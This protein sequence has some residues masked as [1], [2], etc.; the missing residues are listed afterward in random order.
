V[1][2]NIDWGSVP[3]WIGAI[4]TVLA[5]LGALFVFW[6][7]RRHERRQIRRTQITKIHAMPQSAYN[8]SRS[9]D[10]P[11]TVSFSA[12]VSFLLT[13]T[14]DVPAYE[15]HVNLL[16]WNWRH[17]RTVLCNRQIAVAPPS[18]TSGP[19]EMNARQLGEPLDPSPIRRRCRPYSSSCAMVPGSPGGGVT[20]TARCIGAHASRAIRRAS[21]GAES[22]HDHRSGARRCS[23]P[24]RAA[25]PVC[26]A[27][28]RTTRQNDDHEL[29]ANDADRSL[30]VSRGGFGAGR[31]ARVE[32]LAGGEGWVVGSVV[33]SGL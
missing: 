2:S 13:N 8:W 7:N 12:T 9:K 26:G 5:F 3:A 28:P 20:R 27:P 11:P 10:E 1:D 14:A 17:D 24:R 30:F 16:G 6:R 25:R 15:V 23:I 4:G 33:G 19:V 21:A 22:A 18:W 31:A 32:A 29:L